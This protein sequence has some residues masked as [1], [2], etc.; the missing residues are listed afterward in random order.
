VRIRLSF[1]ATYSRSA[2]Y[3]AKGAFKQDD[4]RRIREEQQVEIRR[5]KR[6][7]NISK[8]RN[9]LPSSGQDSDE[10]ISSGSWDP[11]VYLVVFPCSLLIAFHS[12][13]MSSFQVSFQTIP[14]GSSTRPQSSENCCQKR[15]T[16]LLSASSNAALSLASSNS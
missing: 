2:A 8:R 13:Q 9:F 14:K 16:R 3:K 1:I 6:E 15:K 7:E 12:S 5:Q 4:R 11:P 10:D